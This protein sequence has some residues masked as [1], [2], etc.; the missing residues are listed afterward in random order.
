MN[1]VGSY[2]ATIRAW[3]QQLAEEMGETWVDLDYERRRW[4]SDVAAIV[5]LKI[6][7]QEWVESKVESLDGELLTRPRAA[8][9]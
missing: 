8:A 1:P 9:A 4:W 7:R 6:D 5:F 2:D 3:A